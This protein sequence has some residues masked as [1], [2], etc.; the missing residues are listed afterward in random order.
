MTI[1]TVARFTDTVGTIRTLSTLRIVHVFGKISL[2]LGWIHKCPKV[3]TRK[4]V[5]SGRPS[6]CSLYRTSGNQVLPREFGG[7]PI[8]FDEFGRGS[9]SDPIQFVNDE[10]GLF[11]FV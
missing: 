8:L 2:Y 9:A 3:V 7:S 6:G 4:L 10:S 1:N 11:A 5:S